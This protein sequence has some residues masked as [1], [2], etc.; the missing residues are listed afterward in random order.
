VPKARRID[1]HS[2]LVASRCVTVRMAA[3]T[4]DMRTDVH[5]LLHLRVTRSILQSNLNLLVIP[6]RLPSHQ[7]QPTQAW[8]MSQDHRV[9]NAHCASNEHFRAESINTRNPEGTS[10]VLVDPF[11]SALHYKTRGLT[12]NKCLLDFLDPSSR[13]GKSRDTVISAWFMAASA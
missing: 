3:W 7:K 8:M 12:R 2:P 13:C 10:G 4:T 6:S 5:C 11:Y 1:P 9:S